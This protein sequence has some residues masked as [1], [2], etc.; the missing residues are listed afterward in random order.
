MQ[1]LNLPHHV[2]EAF[3]KRCARKLQQQVATWRDT[4]SPARTR[5]DSGVP[6]ERR[7]RRPRLIA[8]ARSA[9]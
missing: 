1:E 3:E 9:S 5:T 2:T 6:V 8:F 7:P 4:R